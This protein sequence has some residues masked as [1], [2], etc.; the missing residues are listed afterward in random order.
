MI[1]LVDLDQGI[2]LTWVRKLIEGQETV[3][4]TDKMRIDQLFFQIQKKVFMSETIV[5]TP[6][7]EM[8]VKQQYGCII[9]LYMDS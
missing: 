3:K 4:I 5:T 1:D 8:Y 9:Y 7:G 6:F 2:N